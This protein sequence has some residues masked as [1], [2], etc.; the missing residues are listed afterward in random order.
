[1]YGVGPR[2][3]PPACISLGVTLIEAAS[4]PRPLPPR[5]GIIDGC[6]KDTGEEM[7]E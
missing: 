5:Y 3:T 1:M 7:A 2:P 4:L 6:Q